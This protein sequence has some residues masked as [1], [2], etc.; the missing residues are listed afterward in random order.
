MLKFLLLASIAAKP[1]QKGLY[2]SDDHVEILDHV[3]Q[4]K[5]LSITYQIFQ[6]NFH[7]ALEDTS[8][9]WI[10][11]FYASWCGHCQHFAPVIRKW[12]D[13]IQNWGRM[14]SI[15]VIDCGDNQNHEICTSNNI[16]G[17]CKNFL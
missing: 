14:V 13:D 3:S 6:T 16:N 4:I 7:S 1:T 8:Q 5:F 9:L 17:K 10:I 12:S 11:E 15:G 2:T